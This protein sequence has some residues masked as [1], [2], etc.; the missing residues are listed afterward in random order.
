MQLARTL[1]AKVVSIPSTVLMV[2]LV[3]WTPALLTMAASRGSFPDS[4][5]ARRA[6]AAA[7]AEAIEERSAIVALAFG[8]PLSRVSSSSAAPGSDRQTTARWRSG[9]LRRSSI[10][11]DFPSPRVAPVITKVCVGES[12]SLISCLF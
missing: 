5:S 6:A 3:I 9:E 2:A 1:T 12:V 8:L 10:A 11:A 7:R 4:S